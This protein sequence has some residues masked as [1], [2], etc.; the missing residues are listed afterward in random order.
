ENRFDVRTLL[1]LG[2]VSSMAPSPDGSWLAVAV[3]RLDAE[4]AKLVSSLW[5]VPLSGDAEAVP[6]TRG[7]SS[8]RAPC[9][10]R[11]GALGFLSD[12]PTKPGSADEPRT[13]VWLLP[14][15]GGE[16]VPLTDEPLG[17]LSFRFAENADVLAL[18][19]PVL[20][21]VAHDEQRKTY[22][23]RKKNGSSAL[24]YA[25]MNVRHWD[26]WLGPAWPH[27]VACDA[28]GRGRRD[29]TPEATREYET[30]ELDHEWALSPTGTHAA[31]LRQRPGADRIAEVALD[32]IDLATGARRTFG[33][34][35]RT[36][37][38]S[39]VFSPDGR[40]LACSRHTRGERRLG[41]PGLWV[42][43][44]DAAGGGAS[45]G[46]ALAERWERWPVPQ[47]WTPDGSALI[48]TA[49]DRG[50]VPIFGVDVA[51]G[52]VTRLSDPKAGGCHD[53]VRVTPAGDALVGVRHRLLSP[54]EPFVMPLGSA[55]AP[56]AV[57]RLPGFSEDDGARIARWESIGVRAPDG[58]EVQSF[59]LLPRDHAAGDAPLP[60]M[61]WIHGGPISAFHDGWHWRWNPLVAVAAG[62][63]VVLPNPRGSTGFGQ[64]FVEQ[65]L[66][67]RWGAEC[68]EDVMATVEAVASRP[69]IDATRVGAMGGSFGGYMANWIGG[70]TDRFRC[71]ITHASLFDLTAFYGTTDYPAFMRWELGTDPYDD[72]E[73][74]ERHSPSRRVTGWKTP[75]L[76]IHGERDYRVPIG[77]GLALF[78][79]L[80]RCG[81]ESELLVFPD[82]NHWIQKPRNIEVWYDAFVEFADRYLKA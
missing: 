12:R 15:R 45:D 24:R 4:R 2:R 77:E 26:A 18:M 62:Y 38:Q 34:A 28:H 64:E 57:G 16:P 56:R 61:V 65:I 33:E 81:V 17:V 7:L 40:R 44:L 71:L 69:E 5:R 13:Q 36:T 76:V 46:R 70:N 79:A 59:L 3:S 30:T 51:S 43:A 6:L 67:N 80:Q 72:R 54:P 23:D 74:F 63:A 75:T 19:A 49:D 29:L 60:L 50:E 31:M 25:T 10:R 66:G 47:A 8:D 14:P 20:V 78:E 42:Y 32:V 27:L 52:E 9:F 21:G 82:E 53:G 35:A 48:V 73:T 41:K 11:D 1:S 22:D 58:A 39:P 37:H 68:Y 55:A